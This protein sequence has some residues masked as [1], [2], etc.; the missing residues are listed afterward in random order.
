MTE[1]IAR[2]ELILYANMMQMT[3]FV[4]PFCPMLSSSVVIFLSV[5]S[6]Q[7]WGLRRSACLAWVRPAKLL[8]ILRQAFKNTSLVTDRH[9]YLDT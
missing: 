2:D 9:M 8:G 6:L 5:N 1:I 4:R 3:S 7:P